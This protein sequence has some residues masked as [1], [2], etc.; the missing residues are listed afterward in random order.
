MSRSRCSPARS[1]PITSVSSR[2]S[3]AWRASGRFIL[4]PEV[5]GVRGGV[6]GATSACATASASPTAPT[7][8]R[9]RCGPRAWVPATRSCMPS[10]TFYATAE[11]ARCWARGRS[12][13]TST[14]D[15]F[16]VT[17]ETVEAALTPRTRAI[18][19]VHLF[20]NV[21]PVP[22]LRDLGRAGDRG[23]GAGRGRGARRHEG[24]RAR[25]RRH[26]LVLPVEE[27]ALPGRR[28]RRS[29]RTTTSWRSA[30]ARLRFH[31]SKD[32]VTFMD[33]GWNS[34]LDELQAAVL[35]VL[36]PELDGWSAARRGAA[37]AYERPASASTWTLPRPVE[38]GASTPTTCTSSPR[39]RRRAAPSWATRHRAAATT[40]C[41]SHRQPAM[42]EYGDGRAAR[43]RGGGPHQLALPMGTASRRT[44][45]ARSWSGVGVERRRL[46]APPR[47][48]NS[49]R[50]SAIA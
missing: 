8:S 41:P 36:L 43:Y 34:R 9:S 11:A 38:R 1:S 13:A 2:R 25:R 16:C 10:F 12:S 40:A 30:R 22:E 3:R 33:V 21:A 27:P 7:R 5:R 18:V 35:R 48:R 20:G 39:A 49:S 46:A 47:P 29:S 42:A 32:K 26:L 6:R 23:R 31:G 17:R 28:R 45:C 44:R 37:E 15:T 14:R 24:R 50:P 19:P 4:G